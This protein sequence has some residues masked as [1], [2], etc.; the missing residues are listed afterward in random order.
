MKRPHVTDHAVVR[1]L[2]QARGVDV[3]AIRDEI[4]RLCRDGLDRGACGVQVDG[5]EFRIE[6]GTIVTVEIPN[7]PSIRTG[8][9]RRRREHDE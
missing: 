6:N 3:D 9:P 7:R 2:E 8:I 4:A 1:F 5:V